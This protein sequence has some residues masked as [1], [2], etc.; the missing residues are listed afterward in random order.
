MS[1]LRGIQNTVAIDFDLQGAI[2]GTIRFEEVCC[3][4]CDGR[5]NS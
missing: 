1:G 2:A 3:N 5:V 4:V